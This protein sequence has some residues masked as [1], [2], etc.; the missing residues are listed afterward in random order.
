MQLER[1]PTVDDL[2]A[3]KKNGDNGERSRQWV[4]ISN[5]VHQGFKEAFKTCI[6][7]LNFEILEIKTN[8]SFSAQIK[9]K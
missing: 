1:Y 8:F 7:V 9:T 2:L 6:L 4:S 3:E 5:K